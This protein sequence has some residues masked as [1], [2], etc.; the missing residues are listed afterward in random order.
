MSAAATTTT[1]DDMLDWMRERNRATKRFQ[2]ACHAQYAQRSPVVLLTSPRHH[3]NSTVAQGSLSSRGGSALSGG[4]LR[5][6]SSSSILASAAMPIGG[7]APGAVAALADRWDEEDAHDDGTAAA[8][9]VANL[10]DPTPSPRRPHVQAAAA[11]SPTL[12]ELHGATSSAGLVPS[13]PYNNVKRNSPSV[14]VYESEFVRVDVVSS[15]S[16]F[17]PSQ[18]SV[19]P[20]TAHVTTGTPRGGS[21]LPPHL[22]TTTTSP[23][24][25]RSPTTTGISPRRTQ[26]VTRVVHDLENDELWQR[27]REL[28]EALSS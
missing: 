10:R 15:T 20:R 24:G 9:S 23:R 28:R 3:S 27:I 13:L 1:V 21:R 22:T 11:I 12:Q 18:K 8:V 19:S 2:D 5:N 7:G 17:P 26:S 16:T 4:K 14:E 25:G 6:H